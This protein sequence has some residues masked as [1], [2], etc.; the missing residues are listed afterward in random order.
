MTKTYK[1]CHQCKVA[2]AWRCHHHSAWSEIVPLNRKARV[3]IDETDLQETAIMPN[4]EAT[5][6]ELLSGR[7]GLWTSFLAT[8]GIPVEINLG[9]FLE[10]NSD[11]VIKANELHTNEFF[12]TEKYVK[13]VVA[14]NDV[15]LYL[16]GREYK[17][18]V[19]MVSG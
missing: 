5:R 7:F 9:I 6:K 4:F 8:L 10:R 12:V 13:D 2:T 16:E 15:K 1:L 19:Y 18:P 3:A 11:D 14:Q 17:V